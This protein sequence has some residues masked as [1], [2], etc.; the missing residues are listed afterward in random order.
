MFLEDLLAAGAVPLRDLEG[1][2]TLLLDATGGGTL[3]ELLL[4]VTG[5]DTLSELLLQATG[6]GVSSP[7]S[8]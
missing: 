6:G 4:A 2:K 5:S 7:L 3:R 8:V 1:L